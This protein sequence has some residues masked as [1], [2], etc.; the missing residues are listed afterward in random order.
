MFMCL[1]GVEGAL[2]VGQEETMLHSATEHSGQVNVLMGDAFF[3]LFFS[4]FLFFS[5]FIFPIWSVPPPP[6]LH[7][8]TTVSVLS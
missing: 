6:L 7:L 4:S 3:F 8:H 5:F 2:P 1:P